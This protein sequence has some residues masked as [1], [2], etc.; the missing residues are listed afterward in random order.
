MVATLKQGAIKEYFQNLLDRI[1]KEVKSQGIGTHEFCGK[2][3]LKEEGLAI[4]KGWRD[5][6]YFQV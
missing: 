4:Q 1:S 2:W 5:V 3:A 6:N